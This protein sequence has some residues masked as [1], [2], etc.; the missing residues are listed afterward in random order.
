MTRPEIVLAALVLTDTGEIRQNITS[1]HSET[2]I[3][4]IATGNAELGE[5]LSRLGDEAEE[6]HATATR[7]T[8]LGLVRAAKDCMDRRREDENAM[9]SLWE[10]ADFLAITAAKALINEVGVERAIELAYPEATVFS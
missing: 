6:L 7:L 9:I 2:A 3:A 5:E 10:D 4:L 8:E 1:S